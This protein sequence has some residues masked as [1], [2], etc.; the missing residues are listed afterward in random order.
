MDYCS[1]CRRHLNGALVCPGCGAYAPD[2]APPPVA[3]TRETAWAFTP[4]PTP[5][6]ESYSGPVDEASADVDADV[7]VDTDGVP[8][9][10]QGRAAR[11]RQMA[12]WKKNQRRAVVATAVALMGGGLTAAAMERDSGAR[13]QA[14]TAPEEVR[15]GT[16]DQQTPPQAPPP[17][18]RPTTPDSSHP[19]DVPTPATNPP[20][21]SYTPPARHAAPPAQRTEANRPET[22]AVPRAQPSDAKAPVRPAATP[23]Q[24]VTGTGTVLPVTDDEATPQP[25]QTTPATGDRSGH[26]LCLLVVCIG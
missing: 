15:T 7:D 19:R 1:A 8:S 25:S 6:H 14:A 11:R 9:L 17:T 18:T 24:P 3:D 20:R 13:A 26:E 23:S 10:P 5:P 4:P 2:I 12:R 16:P 21:Q 22:V